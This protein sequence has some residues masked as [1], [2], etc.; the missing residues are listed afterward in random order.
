MARPAKGQVLEIVRKTKQGPT[1]T[2][3]LRFYAYKKRRYITLNATTRQE[4]EQELANVLADVRRGIWQ[5]SAPALQVAE[6]EPEPT[7]HLF[8]TEW[9]GRR[10]HG[11]DERTVEFWRWALEL[12]LL[13]LFGPYLLSAITPE[14]IDRY[15]AAKVR[16]REQRLVD[17]PLSNGSINRTVRVLAQVLDDAIEYGYMTSNPA[18]GRKRKLQAKRPRRIWLELDEVRSLLDAAGNHRAL[19]A[20]MILAGLR[21]GELCSLRWRSVDLARGVLTVEESKTEAGEGRRIEL[22]PSLLEELKLHRAKHKEASRDGLVFPTLTGRQ[23]DR[24]NV[25][26]RILQPALTRANKKRNEAGL[27]P[28]AH[29]TNHTLRRTFASLLYEA[30]ATP[31]QVMDQLGHTS[32]ALALEVYARKMERNR[33]TLARMD[34][35]VAGSE[36]AAMGSNGDAPAVLSTEETTA[37]AV[38]PLR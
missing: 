37:P 1:R 21:V 32:A 12:H 3:A 22:T 31:A 4:A 15:T 9:V 18:R 14:L 20:T 17:R 30:G 29:A 34:A 8:A 24:N 7:F 6:P 16:E 10:R 19:L 23:R 38:N 25:R 13:P 11:V 28:I 5:P 33:D 2:F 35:L 26:S 36:W 27:P